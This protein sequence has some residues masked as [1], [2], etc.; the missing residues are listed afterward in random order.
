[1]LERAIALTPN[2]AELRV[3]AAEAWDR[4]G[5]RSR[6]IEQWQLAGSSTGLEVQV[7]K[8]EAL[9]NDQLRLPPKQRDF[10]GLTASIKRMRGELSGHAAASDQSADAST[11]KLLAILDMVEASIPDRGVVAEEHLASPAFADKIVSLS[12]KYP[13]DSSIQ[14]FAAERLASQGRVKDAEQALVRLQTI[15]GS[16]TTPLVIAKARTEAAQGQLQSAIEY[17]VEQADRDPVRRVELLRT[18]ALYAANANDLERAYELLSSI[19]SEQRSI[20][21]LFLISKIAAEL[22][23]DSKVFLETD[24]KTPQELVSS[25][26]NKLKEREGESGTHWK[27]LRAN[28]LI[29][30]LRVGPNQEKLTDLRQLTE[31]IL[32]VRPNWGEAISLQGWILALEADARLRDPKSLLSSRAQAESLRHKAVDQL[33]RGISAGDRQ[34]RTRMLLFQLLVSLGETPEAERE[35]ELAISSTNAELD[36]GSTTRISLANRQGQFDRSLEMARKEIEQRPDDFRSHLMLASTAIFAAKNTGEESNRESLFATAADSIEKASEL[37][38]KDEQSVFATEIELA[39][40]KGDRDRLEELVAEVAESELSPFESAMLRYRIYWETRQMELSLEMLREAFKYQKSAENLVSQAAIS[41]ALDRPE[42]AISAL[43]EANKLDPKSE[44]LRY[45]LARSLLAS[46]GRKTIG[47]KSPN[48]F[49]VVRVRLG[50]IASG[51]PDCFTAKGA[52]LG[53]IRRRKSCDLSTKT[54]RKS[55]TTQDGF[56]L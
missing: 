56:L 27:L 46:D 53:E 50:S 54:N 47:M 6:A 4:A 20:E 12:E 26:E 9:F 3:Q 16:Q 22:S 43:R 32:S 52:S 40:A 39:L 23:P 48:C 49:L 29:A 33:R 36:P 10:S 35:L 14:A 18:A 8:L 1:M 25:W 37:T 19:P 17:L 5:D 41:R 15:V 2:N 31:E 7:T 44:Q 11:E 38:S 51:P 34:I 21:L 30:E 13:K 24:E 28:R 42:D 55:A 45:L